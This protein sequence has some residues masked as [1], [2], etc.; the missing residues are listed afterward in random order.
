MGS[1]IW[2]NGMTHVGEFIAD[3]ITGYGV[4]HFSDGSRYEGGWKDNRKH[5]KGKSIAMNGKVIDTVF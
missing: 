2:P 5:G 1:F 3:R 4:R